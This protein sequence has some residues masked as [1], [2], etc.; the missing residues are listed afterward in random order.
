MSHLYIY[1]RIQPG[2]DDTASVLAHAL[3]ASL[4]PHARHARLMRRADDPDTWMEVYE[5]VTSASVLLAA[6]EHAV[7]NSGLAE[8]IVGGATHV[9]H[10][11]PLD[12]PTCA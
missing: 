5:D 8:F 6:R 11:V 10:F 4:A 1:Y 2:A 12:A 3:L 7:A 9:E